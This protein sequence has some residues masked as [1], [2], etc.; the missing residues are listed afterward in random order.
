VAQNN[1]PLFA[2]PQTR[3]PVA[4]TRLRRTSCTPYH[5]H[6]PLLLFPRTR[7]HPTTHP[8]IFSGDN[9]TLSHHL[10]NN[11][12]LGSKLSGVAENIPL[13]TP[14]KITSEKLQ[15]IDPIFG[16]SISVDI[17]KHDMASGCPQ[18]LGRMKLGAMFCSRSRLYR[19]PH[20]FS[21]QSH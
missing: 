1:S 8:T 12:D 14:L 16:N 7:K 6:I 13:L 21:L 3:Y 15:H 17:Q 5:T 4:L 11:L 10:R 2:A 18:Y 9:P 19:K 20:C